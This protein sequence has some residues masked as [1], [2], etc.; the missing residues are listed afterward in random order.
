MY[1]NLSYIP[2]HQ[3]FLSTLLIL[4]TLLHLLWFLVDLFRISC[5][6]RKML[7][8]INKRGRV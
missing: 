5:R 3:S 7:D 2:P 1:N 8:A 6:T 4:S